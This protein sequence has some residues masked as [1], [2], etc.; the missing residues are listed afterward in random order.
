MPASYLD[1]AR[2][3]IRIPSTADRPDALRAA[4]AY[5]ARALAGAPGCT[6]DR[7][8][9][10]GKPSLVAR[11]RETRTPRVLLLGHLDVVPAPPALFTPR[12]EHG[13]LIGRGACD[14]KSEVAV[15]LDCLRELV[16]SATTPPDIALAITSDEEI[17]G[18]DGA[19]YLVDH[20]GYRPAVVFVPDGGEALEEIVRMSKGVLHVRLTARGTSAHGSHPWLGANAIE[21]LVAAALR[22]RHAFPDRDIAEHWHDTCSI[23]TIAGGRA[24]NQVPD[25]ASCTIDLRYTEATDPDALLV[26]VRS[27]AAPCA[28]GVIAAGPVR[29]TAPDDPYLMRY[30]DVVRKTI[31][32]EIR[33]TRTHGADDGRH[34]AAHDVPIIVS[35]PRSG[36]QHS[37]EEWVDL[38]SLEEFRQCL[39]MFLAEVFAG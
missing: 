5:A 35:R 8:E 32:R 11:T 15:M 1:M 30:T 12:E 17:G 13:Q 27:L 33:F 7:F 25:L 38:S 36:G 29:E 14:M 19:A 23:G 16:A 37:A 21:T 24:T 28:V 20:L 9:R 10:N 6:I 2:D 4:I 39:R 26:R 31:G 22:I 18:R 3:L 34:F